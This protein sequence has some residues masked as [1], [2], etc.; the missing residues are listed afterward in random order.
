LY[1]IVKT[2]NFYFHNLEKVTVQARSFTQKS[3]GSS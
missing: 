1:N 3:T 2:N